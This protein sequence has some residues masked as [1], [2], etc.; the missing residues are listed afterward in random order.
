MK[1]MIISLMS[2]SL[3]TGVANL[4]MAEDTTVIHKESGDGMH[5]KTV[6]KHSNG[7]KTVVKRHGTSVKKS[8][9]EPNGNKTVIEKN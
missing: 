1:I 2:A 8:H 5:S 3:L 9:T 7:A 4:A 6:V